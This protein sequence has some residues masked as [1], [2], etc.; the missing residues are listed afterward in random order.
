MKVQKYNSKNTPMS[1]G[2]DL[3]YSDDAF[4]SIQ[5][6]STAAESL[7]AMFELSQMDAT[8]QAIGQYNEIA[9]AEKADNT[10]IPVAELNERF[11]DLS[12]PFTEPKNAAVAE[13][14]A[15]RQR[16]RQELGQKINSGPDGFGMGIA[17]FGAALIPHAID[18]INVG[19]GVAVSALTA[20]IGLIAEGGVAIKAARTAVQAA[21][22]AGV[23]KE[24]ELAAVAARAA[25]LADTTLD[26]ASAWGTAVEATRTAGMAQRALANPFL[27]NFGEGVIGNIASEAIVARAAV[28]EGRDYGLDDIFYN[29]VG[30]ALL[31]PGA[32]LGF[33][34]A[35]QGL[36]YTGKFAINRS[37]AFLNRIDP[38]YSELLQSTSLGRLMQDKLPRA[39][40][41]H[42]H[43]V[44]ELKGDMPSWAGRDAQYNFTRLLPEDFK[45]R[46]VYAASYER[47][48]A[49]G[50][51]TESLDAFL[52][53]GVYATDNPIVANGAAAR[54]IKE[55]TGAVI[56]LEATDSLNLIN[57]NE[58][59]PE[60]LASVF[61]GHGVT[62]A[63][64]KNKSAMEIM[65]MIQDRVQSNDL[66][67]RFI[68]DLNEQLKAQGFDGYHSDGSRIEGEA[69][70]P[71]NSIVVFNKEKL[72]EI[73]EIEP[74]ADKIGKLPPEKVNELHAESQSEISQL[75]DDNP[76]K[77]IDDFN[78]LMSQEPP[79]LAL[80]D[81]EAAELDLFDNVMDLD[82]QGLL[83]ESQ[84]AVFEE[85]RLA[86]KDAEQMATMMKS[87]AACVGLD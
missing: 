60:N 50:G 64:L 40:V 15:N 33:Q 82:K 4:N 32:V 39:D 55:T 72:K 18:P 53:S 48:G 6:Q 47:G 79:N 81:L 8:T 35:A 73:R 5:P 31:V 52:G 43:A 21:R 70:D 27:R 11:A 67:P 58:K 17:R 19:S 84:K 83:T 62:K 87:A 63:D 2:E 28:Q 14:I 22:T 16:K 61:Q 86:Q 7:G 78:A 68:E 10:L 44:V 57:L 75:I 80:K 36:R 46:R 77:T 56:E 30:G 37:A 59:V 38:K 13:I 74:E 20:G 42:Q 69:M 1:M 54:S 26:T 76:Q 12:E 71:H 9:S 29:T 41:F 66:P 85:V 3:D 51:Q 45:G 25:K 24:A 49:L 34:K 65:E 23:V